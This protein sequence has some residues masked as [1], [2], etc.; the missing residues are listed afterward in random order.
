MKKLLLALTMAVVLSLTLAT[1]A[2]AD[3]GNGNMGGKNA[4]TLPPPW[5]NPLRNPQGW[6]VG[7][8]NGLFHLGWGPYMAY[9]NTG[10]WPDPAAYGWIAMSRSIH[11]ILNG[12][13]P[14]KPH[15]AGGQ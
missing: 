2:F 6:I 9:T 10:E 12:E 7:L 8:V 11:Y 14:A 13:P 4:G 1:P 15:W 3:E 5:T